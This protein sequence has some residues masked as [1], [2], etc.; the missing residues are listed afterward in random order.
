M[1]I[2]ISDIADHHDWL[3]ASGISA[4]LEP[5]GITVEAEPINF[6][7]Q[8]TPVP[9][10]T[11]VAL[12]FEVTGFDSKAFA[13]EVDKHVGKKVGSKRGRKPGRN[14]PA[15]PSAPPSPV[16]HVKATATKQAAAAE[17]LSEVS[18]RDAV[19]LAIGQ[20]GAADCDQ[21]W[22]RARAHQ[23]ELTRNQVVTIL[24]QL[25]ATGEVEVGDDKM[26]SPGDNLKAVKVG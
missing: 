7:L 15:V 6:A 24:S 4:Q 3:L 5:L 21:I 2:V 20:F 17:V 9:V 22:S 26:W 19:R 23:P 18:N 14:S 16:R 12:G 13:S 10:H 1:K 11:N 8:R 25:Q